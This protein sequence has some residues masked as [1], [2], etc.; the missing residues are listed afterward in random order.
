M[1]RLL[2]TE[3]HKV[4][5]SSRIMMNTN[6]YQNIALTLKQ[7][8]PALF[9]RVKQRTDDRAVQ[10]EVLDWIKQSDLIGFSC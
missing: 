9:Q 1:L 3:Q 8:N 2:P 7:A 5:V 4:V 10:Q 6:P